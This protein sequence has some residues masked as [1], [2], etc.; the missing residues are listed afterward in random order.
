MQNRIGI[1][2]FSFCVKI[3]ILYSCKK[4]HIERNAPNFKSTSRLYFSC[5]SS[6]KHCLDMQNQKN[7]INKEIFTDELSKKGHKNIDIYI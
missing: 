1:T 3:Y 4:I 6:I 5:C 2:M 7:N